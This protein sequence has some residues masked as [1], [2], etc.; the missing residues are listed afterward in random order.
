[1]IRPGLGNWSIT[2]NEDFPRPN[3]SFEWGRLRHPC[4][5]PS[6]TNS[7]AR[8][9]A[10]NGLQRAGL[11]LVEEQYTYPRPLS[12]CFS[13]T[14]RKLLGAFMKKR[15]ITSTELGHNLF[16]SRDSKAAFSHAGE[17]RQI[18]KAP[19]RELRVKIFIRDRLDLSLRSTVSQGEPND[20]DRRSGPADLM[21]HGKVLSRTRG[22]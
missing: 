3:D 11:R 19:T 9:A 2:G 5:A 4:Q 17:S 10:M 1:M 6:R 15:G 14:L 7:T 12:P 13:Y 21:T 8:Q 20:F 22:S 16:F 18:T